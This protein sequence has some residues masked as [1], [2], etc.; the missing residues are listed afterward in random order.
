MTRGV[1]VSAQRYFGETRGW[2]ACDEARRSGIIAARETHPGS[3]S[4]SG[5]FQPFERRRAG[6]N[7][8]P[9][10]PAAIAAVGRAGG[11]GPGTRMRKDEHVRMMCAKR[12]EPAPSVGSPSRPDPRIGRRCAPLLPSPPRPRAAARGTVPLPRRA[13]ACSGP[14]SLRAQSERDGGWRDCIRGIA[15]DIE[16]STGDSS[17]RNGKWREQD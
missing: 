8:L 5:C 15:V 4:M 1:R 13:G 10:F 9:G 6:S 17:I 14:P 12:V 11:S 3:A 16:R 2:P 7:R